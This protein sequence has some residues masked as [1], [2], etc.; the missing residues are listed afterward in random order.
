MRVTEWRLME[1]AQNGVAQARNR[2]A[3]A[4]EQMSSGVRVARPSDDP[5]SWAE[6][7]RTRARLAVARGQKSAIRT[8]MENLSETELV[9]SSIGSALSRSFVLA[10]QL[11]NGTNDADS[12]NLAAAEIEDL[13]DG[14]LGAA[15]SK[16]ARGE[17]LLAGVTS[18]SQPF[19]AA[20]NFI[21]ST[22]GRAVQIREGQDLNVTVEGD[23][24]STGVNVVA[25][26]DA[27]AT[28]LRNNDQDAIQAA[29]D[30]LHIA[31]EQTA[32]AQS[33]V[34]RRV[35]ALQLADQDRESVEISLMETY[36]SLIEAEPIAAASEL[37]ESQ[38][39]L[40]GARAVAERLVQIAAG[41]IG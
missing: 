1:N 32:G 37:A 34:G 29:M 11:A 9:F 24:L 18:L 15:N 28:G 33:E 36:A 22:S 25:V 39:A 5:V 4:G 2:A 19:D 12:R 38:I 17:Y 26:M 27:L 16:S 41:S 40:E 31:I 14:I 3:R 13:R 10:T 20:G 7:A 8:S 35:S 23:H 6:G 21:G 30:D